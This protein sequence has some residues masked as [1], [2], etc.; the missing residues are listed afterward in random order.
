MNTSSIYR[1][2]QHLFI[3]F[4]LF[5]LCV[6]Q[7][8]SLYWLGYLFHLLYYN[9]CTICGLLS[10]FCVVFFHSNFFT[11]GPI[12]NARRE[13]K[14]ISWK[15]FHKC[16]YIWHTCKPR[17]NLVE[18]LLL[19]FDKPNDL[20]IQFQPLTYNCYES[21]LLRHANIFIFIGNHNF[22]CWIMCKMK[23]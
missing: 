11:L 3:S 12:Y 23:F 22:I 18:L 17:M 10:M 8:Q 4:H 9:L 13:N 15:Q 14:Q 19:L 1:P 16:H 2:H 21:N 7:R 5:F 6:D 20:S